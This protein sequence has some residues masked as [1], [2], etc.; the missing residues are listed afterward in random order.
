MTD[1]SSPTAGVAPGAGPGAFDSGVYGSRG[2]QLVRGAGCHV[3]D[4][5]GRRYLD[6]TSMVGVTSLGHGHPA[7]VAAVQNQAR[8]LI[9]CMGSF[10]NDARDQL[11]AR[12]VDLLDRERVAAGDG[13]DGP[14]RLDRVFLCN[15]G[16]EAVEAALKLAR[17]FTGRP[18]TVA[19][20]GA[21][22][23]RT[24]GSLSASFRAKYREAFAPLLPGFS[25]VRPGDLAALRRELEQGDVA[26]LVVEPVQGEGGVQVVDPSFLGAARAACRAHGTLFVADEVQTGCGRTGAYARTNALGLDPDLVC[27]A[28]G[29]GGGFPIGATVFA[30]PTDTTLTGL[31]GSTFGGNPLAC[32]AADAVL[33]TLA[34]LDLPARATE[35]GER[36]LATLRARLGPLIGRAVRDVRGCGLMVG[37][38]LATSSVPVQRALQERGVLTL[39][40]G[41]RVLRLLPP[42]TIDESLLDELTDAVVEEIER[43]DG[44]AGATS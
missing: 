36:W 32:A 41:A 16:T 23:G 11:Q 39:G 35:L 10:G 26:A 43:L 13:S 6:A 28:K 19:L 4:D 22:H 38:E 24:M 18:R 5:A 27:L 25:H 9:S 7:L 2:L 8:R 3:F 15:S 17:L 20:S 30:Q 40:A 21:F 14:P 37:I 1:S 33:S 34:E 42:L 31:H 12:L 29:L 44:G